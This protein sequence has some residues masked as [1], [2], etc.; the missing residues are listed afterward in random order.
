MFKFSVSVH[1]DNP[2][3]AGSRSHL[4]SLFIVL[5]VIHGTQSYKQLK[6]TYQEAK[7]RWNYVQ[8]RQNAHMF[9]WLYYTTASTNYQSKPLVLWLQGG[10]GGSSTGFGNFGEIGPLDV[11]Q[12]PRRTTWLSK[13][14]LLFI[15]NPVGAGFSYVTDDSAY[16]TN[17]DM[18]AADLLTVLMAFLKELP[19]FRT[20]PFFI[21]CE[22]YGGKMTAGFSLALQKAIIARQIDCNFKGFALGDSWI[23]PWD[24]TFTWGPY[25]K[26]TSLIDEHGLQLINGSVVVARKAYDNGKYGLATDEWGKT[27]EI[28]ESLT[29]GV[30]FYN[31][32]QWN[33]QEDTKHS[34]KKYKE[35]SIFERLVHRNLAHLSSDSLDQLMNGPIRKKLGI[36]PRN[37]TWGGQSD[38]VFEH[39]KED[40]MKP[41]VNV[42]DELLRMSNL[43][44]NIYTGQLDLIVDTLGTE[45]WVQ[46]LTWPYLHQFN[47]AKRKPLLDP[48]KKNPIA[49][50]KQYKNLGFYWILDAGHMVPADAGEAALM[51]LDMVTS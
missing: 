42:V 3:M 5:G 50:V 32:L 46:K 38:K 14:S 30:N 44:V 31:I 45:A 51:M 4:I 40:F 18:I 29:G 22:S 20:I 39:L 28:L 6:H 17:N 26:A 36:I 12:N 49:F 41:V 47:T 2:N 13:V 43:S 19:D 8:V 33:S 9:W 48:L 10:P 15:D 11:N 35:Q 24:S 16:T 25:L 1:C 34:Y 37:V 23:S 7:Q 27:Q 21:F